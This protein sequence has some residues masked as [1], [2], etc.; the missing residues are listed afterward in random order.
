MK[1]FKDKKDYIL[2][3]Y[4]FHIISIILILITALYIINTTWINPPDKTGVGLVIT[5]GTLEKS[6]VLK[7]NAEAA[8]GIQPGYELTVTALPLDST[9]EV[10]Y[11][12]A[13]QQKL[14]V[15]LVSG[16][17]DLVIGVEDFFVANSTASFFSD[18]SRVL[19]DA[20]YKNLQDRFIMGLVP[21]D[22]ADPST[23]TENEKVTYKTQ[24]DDIICVK[25]PIG[26]RLDGCKVLDDLGFRSAGSV[27][28]FSS[29]GK[30]MEITLKLLDYLLGI[31]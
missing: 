28:G 13:M 25:R 22:L 8:I 4:K 17:A 27:I 21:V 12:Q 15:M 5:N 20:K 31:Q 2:D 6:A 7:S 19:T 11:A 24:T 26:I 3:Y 23:V 30:R 14:V 10:S 1:S 9:Q 18:L 16:D 29:T